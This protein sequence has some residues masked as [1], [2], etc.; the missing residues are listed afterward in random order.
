MTVATSNIETRENPFQAAGVPMNHDRSGLPIIAGTD[1]DF[2]V[3]AVPVHH[4]TLSPSGV[5]YK[6]EPDFVVVRRADTFHA[7]G[8]QKKSYVP[9][10]NVEAFDLLLGRLAEEGL[11]IETAIG[12]REGARSFIQARLPERFSV[13]GD[14]AETFVLILN[15]FDGSTGLSALLGTMRLRCTN[16]LPAI[17]RGASERWTH[18]HSRNVKAAAADAG[19]LLAM[20][21]TF[22]EAQI[23]TIET[24]Q[25]I[26]VTDTQF[27]AIV[28]AEFP[29]DE[30]KASTRKKDSITVS[31]DLTRF[32]Y[33]NDRDGGGF[34]GT[35]WGV[36]QAFS[37]YDLWGKDVKG[38]RATTQVQNF[39]QG[40]YT[41]R[42]QRVTERIFAQARGSL[43]S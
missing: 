37:S 12:T 20:A 39:A 30:E 43:V 41:G 25:R 10:S 32:L 13:G 40:R 17:R 21:Q 8:A 29:L 34:Q 15:S 7:F 26:E 2:P 36:L 38:D 28:E 5:G 23:E 24:L 42:V 31:R 6:E 3:E 22:Q 4:L 35:G 16:V 14:E 9:V 11:I 1:L 33:E 18:R 19:R 27:Q